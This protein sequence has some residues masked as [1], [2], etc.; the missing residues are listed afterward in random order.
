MPSSISNGAKSSRRQFV[1]QFLKVLGEH[2]GQLTVRCPGAHLHTHPGEDATVFLK[3]VPTLWCFHQSCKAEVEAVNR[4]IWARLAELPDIE[5]RK[6][7]PEEL[8]ERE[9]K[10]R[11]RK[12]ARIAH[13]RVL[14]AL[15]K[16]PLEAWERE[17]PHP[18]SLY[19][20]L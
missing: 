2:D 3:G 1:G 20:T 4:E 10:E 16:V 18:V 19:W 11:L 5:D 14:P 6:R 12:L 8:A 9:F 13:D 7:T 17:S 15:D